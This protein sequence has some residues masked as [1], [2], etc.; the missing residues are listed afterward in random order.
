MLKYLLN[1]FIT[2][3]AIALSILIVI[4]VPGTAQAAESTSISLA[5]NIDLVNVVTVYP[6]IPSTQAKVLSEVMK[7]EQSTFSNTPGFQDSAILKAQD[8]TQVI[9]LSQW[10]GKDLSSFQS[11]A[12]EHT[13][14]VPNSPFPQTFACQVQHTETKTTSPQFQAKDIIMFSQFKMKQGKDQSELAGIISQEMP[15]VLEMVPGLQW[16]AMC[17]ST[18]QSTIALLARWNSA[19]DFQSLGQKPGF[20]KETNYWQAYANNEHGLYEVAQ[21]IR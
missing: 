12:K 10:K 19:D 6:T 11:Y 17:P 9:A 18:D 4:G 13:L 14:T 15:G 3:V 2:T 21:T 16:A 8:G 7:G 5:E 20:D 1:R